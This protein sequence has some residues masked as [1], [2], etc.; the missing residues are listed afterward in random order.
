[1]RTG[2]TLTGTFMVVAAAILWGVNGTVSRLVL[3]AGVDPLRLTQLRITGAAMVLLVWLAVRERSALRLR[4]REWVAFAVFGVVGLVG[5]QWLYFE[6]IARIPIGI[7]LVIEYAAPLLVALWV[8]LVWGRHLPLVAW[9]ALPLALVGLAL[10]IGLPQGGGVR[11][12][13]PL[14][15]LAAAG[16]ALA[17]AY[18]GLHAEVL[19]RRRSAPA[20]LGLG[21]LTA[22][23]ALAVALPWWSFPFAALANAPP[24]APFP[25]EALWYALYVIV[26][27]TLVPFTLLIAGVRRI[28]ADGASVTAM[29]EPILAGAVAWVVLGQ[30]LRPLQIVG[31]CLVLLAVTAAQVGRAR[32]VG[33]V[34]GG[35]GSP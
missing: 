32:A 16:A 10:A 18:Y 28:G 33:S 17:Y 6:A 34:V 30:V 24:T 4:G 1:M 7:A 13:A 21:L 12:L 25:I 31:A 23:L 35:A 29:L 14:G 19:T 3:D 11:A 9:L 5:V 20:V 8:R 26:L 15:V 27:G 2:T 22:T